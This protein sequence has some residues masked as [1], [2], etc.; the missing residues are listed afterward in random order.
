MSWEVPAANVVLPRSN[1]ADVAVLSITVRDTLLEPPAMT[2]AVPSAGAPFVV[3]GFDV[4]GRPEQSIQHVSRVATLVVVGDRP[5]S[6]VVGCAGAP[7]S[8][9]RSV[10]GIVGACGGVTPPVVVPF[11]V[12]A[13]WIKRYVPGGLVLPRMVTTRLEPGREPSPR[14]TGPSREKSRT[15]SSTT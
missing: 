5:V 4:S 13:S 12:I 11:A 10:F 2:L 6:A 9:G 3:S 7:V 14:S 8:V 15:S 1:L